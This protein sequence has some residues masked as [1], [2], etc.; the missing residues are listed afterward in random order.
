[1]YIS[2]IFSKKHVFLKKEVVKN[3]IDLE[4]QGKAGF[5]K[6]KHQQSRLESKFIRSPGSTKCA[7]VGEITKNKRAHTPGQGPANSMLK[8]IR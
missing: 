7:Q 4:V 6:G 1:L 3:D 5:N 8:F 2:F